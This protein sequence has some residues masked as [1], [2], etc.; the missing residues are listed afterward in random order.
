M[1]KDNFIWWALGGIGALALWY[2]YQNNKTW[3]LFELK[4]FYQIQ[5]FF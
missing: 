2:H 1:K 4:I 5:N 3:F